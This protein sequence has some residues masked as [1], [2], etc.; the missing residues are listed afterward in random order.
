M[1]YSIDKCRVIRDRV[2]EVG[3]YETALEFGITK[4]SVKRAMRYLK[5]DESEKDGKEITI[6]RR[7]CVL[8]GGHTVLVIGDLHCPFDLEG[9]FD[10]VCSV[11]SVYKPDVI[12]FIG[13]V[14]DN[15][16]ASYHETDPDGLGGRDELDLAVKRLKRWH[17]AFPDAYVTI[18]NHD[19]MVMRKSQTSHIPRRWIKS[20]AEVLETPSWYFTDRVDIDGVQYIHGEAGTARTKCKMDMMST[21]QGHL[22]TQAYTDWHVGRRFKVFGMQVGCGIDFSGYAMAYA[23]AGRKPAI[24]CGIII[25]GDVAINRMMEL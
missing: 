25:N 17:T 5:Q 10:F 2:D 20:Y 3:I 8:D 22:H 7:D 12:V 16:Y 11:A 9:Y 23:K 24:G 13:D 15:H 18:G 14:V 6:E 1:A 19:R 21:V 4:E